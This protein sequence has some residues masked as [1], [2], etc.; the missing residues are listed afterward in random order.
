MSMKAKIVS[1]ELLTVGAAVGVFYCATEF[2]ARFVP[3]GGMRV[4][5]CG[6]VL[7]AVLGLLGY[8]N[9]AVNKGRAGWLSEYRLKT[10][11]DDAESD[12]DERLSRLLREVRSPQN[13]SQEQQ[14]KLLQSLRLA[15]VEIG[16]ESLA[17]ACVRANGRIR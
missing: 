7:I 5:F 6:V 14:E 4:F 8:L 9:D 16:D 12:A 11:A 13:A 2:A 3:A 15:A 10:L 1:I 17:Q